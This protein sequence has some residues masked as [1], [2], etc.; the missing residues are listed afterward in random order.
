MFVRATRV[1]GAILACAA[2]CA[3]PAAATTMPER[4]PDEVAAASEL[5]VEGTVLD[6]RVQVV[7]G[8]IVTQ[9]TVRVEHMV[10]AATHVDPP[11]TVSVVLPGGAIGGIGQRVAGT[12]ELQ[13]GSRYVLCLSAPVVLGARTIVGLWQGVWKVGANDALTP[14]THGGPSTTVTTRAAVLSALGGAP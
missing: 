5:V 10:R 8:R 11:L 2:L 4:G 14:F 9:H 7:G 3:P 6:A 12:P 1:F 13:V